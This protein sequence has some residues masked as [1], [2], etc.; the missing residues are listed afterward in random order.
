[1]RAMFGFL[2][3]QAKDLSD[4][5][6]NAKAAAAWLRQLPSLDVIGRQQ[7]VIE[8]LDAMRKSQRALAIR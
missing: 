8:V 2:T 6:Q 4:P 5:L 3:P 7:Q 1:M